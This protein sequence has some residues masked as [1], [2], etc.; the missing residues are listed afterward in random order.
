MNDLDARDTDGI[1]SAPG[2]A[3]AGANRAHVP[4]RPGLLIEGAASIAT[5][6]GGLRRGSAQGDAAIERGGGSGAASDGRP[7]LA[8]AA[9]GDR[10]IA[11]GPPD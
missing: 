5:L 11:A 4:A 3:L 7:A 9:W 2:R 6:A 1:E 10:L 8:V